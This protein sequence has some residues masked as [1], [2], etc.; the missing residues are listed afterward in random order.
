M[1]DVSRYPSPEAAATTAVYAIGDLHGRLDLMEAMEDA[2][3]AD[4]ASYRPAAPLICYLGDYIDRGPASAEIIDR[5][6]T[7]FDDDVPRVYLRGNH[8][9]QLLDF[10]DDPVARG[11][12]WTQYGGREALLSYGVSLPPRLDTA[13]WLAARDALDAALPDAHRRFLNELRLA[14]VWRDYIFVHAGLDPARPVTDQS[15]RDLVWIREPFS[16]SRTDWGYRVVHGHVIVDR[17]VFRPNRIGIDTGAYY[18][19]RLTCVAIDDTGTRI[20]EARE[21]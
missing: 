10:L 12:S 19:G 9:E 16:S 17:P 11:P 6:A 21:A 7:G 20:I 13:A 3:R 18:S 5:F 8:E 2:I 4:I 14:F 15:P 1:L